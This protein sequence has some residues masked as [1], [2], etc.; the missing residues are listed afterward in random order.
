MCKCLYD[1]GIDR[2]E[3][4]EYDQNLYVYHK[5][6]YSGFI[7]LAAIAVR[8]ADAK[9]EQEKGRFTAISDKFITEN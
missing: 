3:M 8:V 1:N 4:G 5:G 7:S 2:I 6:Q 9:E